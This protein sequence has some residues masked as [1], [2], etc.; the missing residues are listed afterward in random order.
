ML[1][2]SGVDVSLP[3][4]PGVNEIQFILAA[5]KEFG[6]AA[7]FVIPHPA[8]PLPPGFPEDNVTR[9]P[10]LRRRSPVSWLRQQFARFSTIRMLT[11][12]LAPAY[13]VL[14]TGAFPVAE[15]LARR[16]MGNYYLKTAGSG[17]FIVFGQSWWGRLLKPLHA[18]LIER[19]A[20]QSRGLDVVSETHRDSLERIVRGA[21]GKVEVFDNAADTDLFRPRDTA[22]LR[23]RLGLD[24]FRYLVGYVGNLAHERGGRELLRCWRHI[25][26]RDDVALLIV[27]G[28]RAG[29]AELEQLAD[30][31]GIRDR[32]FILGPIPVGDVAQYM[33]LLDVGVSF[34]DDDGCSELKV[35]QYLCCGV[36]VLVS[37]RVNAFVDAAGI[38]ITVPRDRPDLIGAAASAILDGSACADR[39]A[40]RHYAE[41]HL[42]YAAT[43]RQRRRF[44]R[45]HA[46]PMPART[47]QA[48]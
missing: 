33:S 16:A 8:R 47:R 19:L 36:P 40:V 34:R 45:Q 24:G 3:N 6:R 18:T 4:G 43:M 17:E 48:Q 13:V 26:Q 23:H 1:Y 20:A 22:E 42:S 32:T 41:A 31:L 35:R 14:R 39:A 2:V 25:A 37:A 27:S 21:R 7:R 15:A 46:V 12:Q 44:W 30:E 10:P 5:R 9:L 11:R 29:V 28:D 38:G